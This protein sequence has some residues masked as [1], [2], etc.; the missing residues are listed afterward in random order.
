MECAGD[1]ILLILPNV[2]VGLQPGEAEV[3]LRLHPTCYEHIVA[4]C[5][6]AGHLYLVKWRLLSSIWFGGPPY[7]ALDQLYGRLSPR[8][9]PTPHQLVRVSRRGLYL[10]DLHIVAHIV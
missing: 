8:P 3:L 6:A 2:D 7:A 10:G 4:G 1:D 9:K 5:P